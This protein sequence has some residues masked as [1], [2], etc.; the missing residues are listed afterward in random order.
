MDIHRCKTTFLN[1]FHLRVCFPDLCFEAKND[2][3][4]VTRDQIVMEKWEQNLKGEEV[5]KYE[6]SSKPE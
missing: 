3:Q 2:S 5:C 6:L 4:Q 1:I